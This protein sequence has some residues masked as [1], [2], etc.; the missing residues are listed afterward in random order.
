M[1]RQSHN[2]F[3]KVSKQIQCKRDLEEYEFKGGRASSKE[4]RTDAEVQ[5]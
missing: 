3:Y 5:M 4:G 1:S 2:T